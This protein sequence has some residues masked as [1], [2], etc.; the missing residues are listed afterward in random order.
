MERVIYADVLFLMNFGCDLITVCLTSR[1]CR[2]KT[3]PLKAVAAAAVGALLSLPVT[4]FLDGFTSLIAGIPIA[5]LTCFV[6]FGKTSFSELLRRTAVTWSSACLLFGAASSVTRFLNSVFGVTGRTVAALSCAA[7]VPF[8]IIASRFRRDREEKRSAYLKFSVCGKTVGVLCLVDSGDLLREPVS[9]DPVVIVASRAVTQIPRDV[10]EYLLN[11]SGEPPPGI[12]PRMRI[13]PA[14]TLI[15]KEMMRAVRPECLS[16]NGT[17]RRA[18]VSLSNAEKGS[19][20]TY[21]GVLQPSI[22]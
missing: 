3:K 8:V 17:E 7:S 19:F 5:S 20:G 18:F 4:L 16:V 14:K 22:T 12:A 15:G 2:I 21:D 11:G 6:A 9:G 10:V 13:I 1:L